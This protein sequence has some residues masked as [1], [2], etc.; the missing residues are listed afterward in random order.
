MPQYHCKTCDYK[1]KNKTD[2]VRHI[3]TKKHQKK[4]NLL[5]ETGIENDKKKDGAFQNPCHPTPGNQNLV[6]E[7]CD[8]SL[9]SRQSYSRHINY[10]CPNNPKTLEIKKNMEINKLK[11]E[12]KELND[13]MNKRFENLNNNH[14]NNINSNN[15]NGP[16]LNI[17]G[18]QNTVTINNNYTMLVNFGCENAKHISDQQFK[19]LIINANTMVPD[20]AKL[21]HFNK[22]KNEFHNIKIIDKNGK[23]ILTYENGNWVP[24]DISDKIPVMINNSKKCIEDEYNDRVI[25]KGIIKLSEEEIHNYQESYNELKNILKMGNNHSKYLK[26]IRDYHKAIINGSQELGLV[27]SNSIY[28]YLNF[29]E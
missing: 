20:M 15:R 3:K 18:N 4:N 17:T 13:K 11:E 23:H 7:F 28:N 19:N 27:E 21:I 9:S 10:R 16:S 2:Y 26:F 5:K 1:T 12:I 14:N 29:L 25:E 22:A 24:N 6:C 8:K